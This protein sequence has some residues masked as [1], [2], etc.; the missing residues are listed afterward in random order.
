MSYDVI[1][2][3]AGPAGSTAAA[4]LAN[5]GLRTLLMD[6]ATFPRAKTCGDAI[7]MAA[8]KIFEAIGLDMAIRN[9]DFYRI[10]RVVHRNM[11][12][13]T[14]IFELT[15]ADFST[16]EA[17][18][19]PRYRFDHLLF[20][21]ALACGAIFEQASATVPI[22][23]NGHVVGVSGKRMLDG[24]DVNY[25]APV[26]IVAD[27]A[28]S[29][30][31][32]IL[33]PE[34]HDRKHIAVAIR[35][36]V[37]TTADLDPAIEIEFMEETLPG[38]AWFF[39]TSKRR[40]NI[41]MGIRSDFYTQQPYSLQGILD[42]YCQKPHIAALIGNHVIHDVKSWQI[43]LFSF[44]LQRVFDGAIL[45]GDA[46]HFVNQITGDGIYEALFTGRCAAETIIS[47]SKTGDFSA[48]AL[49]SFDEA[50]Q[51]QLGRRFKEA[52]ILNTMA[53]IAPNIISRAIF[54]SDVEHA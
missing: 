28:T 30:I 29:A 16:S 46:G 47:A 13:E 34:R 15:N 19:A 39:P 31:A 36:Y 26:L 5:A 27:G 23:E 37:E 50:W 49:S 32:R 35:G 33:S 3:G 17:F 18:I 1:V 21:H 10:K 7:P 20:E 54:H 51:S 4:F 43:P 9:A 53:T 2:V 14:S 25:R 8:Y 45:V 6:R 12:S 11:V 38:Y 40:A 42:L 44:D 22:I 24:G 41:G 52:E 48:E